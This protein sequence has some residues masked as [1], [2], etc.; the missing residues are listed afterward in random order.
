MTACGY[1]F[2]FVEYCSKKAMLYK[3]QRDERTATV[4]AKIV[5]LNLIVLSHGQ[6]WHAVEDFGLFIL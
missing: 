2:I 5:Q 6:I 3:I 1:C 4:S